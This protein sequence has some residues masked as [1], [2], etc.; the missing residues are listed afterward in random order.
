MCDRQ[1]SVYTYGVRDTRLF[2]AHCARATVADRPLSVIYT[3]RCVRV[4]VHRITKTPKRMYSIADFIPTY[5]VQTDPDVAAKLAG[6]PEFRKEAGRWNEPIPAAGELFAHQRLFVKIM[7]VYN[8]MLLISEPGTGKTLSFVAALEDLRRGQITRRAYIVERGTAVLND[9]RGQIRR[10]TGEAVTPRFYVFKTYASLSNEIRRITD[11]EQLIAEYSGCAFVLDEAHTISNTADDAAADSNKRYPDI[12]RLLRLATQTTVI[13]ATATPMINRTGELAALANLIL[14]PSRA[15]PDAAR[16]GDLDAADVETRMRGFVSFVRGEPTKTRIHQVGNARDVGSN[17]P[18]EAWPILATSVMGDIQLETY[19]KVIASSRSPS[20]A[21]E[22]INAWYRATL[23]ACAF[24]FPRDEYGGIAGGAAT[25]DFDEIDAR[26][27]VG[28]GRY[29]EATPTPGVYAFVDTIALR[30]RFSSWRH[31]NGARSLR[32]WIAGAGAP[33]GARPTHNLAR[34]SA[35]FARIIDIEREALARGEA[36]TSFV[37][38]QFKNGG[39]AILLGLVLEAFG[40]RRFDHHRPHHRSTTTTNDNDDNNNTPAAQPAYALL[41]PEIGDATRLLNAFNA[42]ENADGSHIR[43]II[44][45]QVSRD[46]I[47]LYHVTRVHILIPQ[48]NMSGV[49]QA[50]ARAIR[51]VSHDTLY[52]RSRRSI[53]ASRGVAL[54]TADAATLEAIAE[55]SRVTVRVF[56]HAAVFPNNNAAN[57]TVAAAGVVI[58]EEGTR[59]ADEELYAIATNKAY[60]IARVARALRSASVDC[61]LNRTRNIE[62]PILVGAITNGSPECDYGDCAYDCSGSGVGKTPLESIAVRRLAGAEPTREELAR[63]T[64]GLIKTL[65]SLDSARTA[66]GPNAQGVSLATV[67]PIERRA[68]VFTAARTLAESGVSVRTGH[69]RIGYMVITTCNKL[70]VAEDIT[71]IATAALGGHALVA[72]VSRDAVE[73]SNA[74]L[75]AINRAARYAINDILGAPLEAFLASPTRPLMTSW[76]MIRFIE[77]V[78]SVE[79]EIVTLERIATHLILGTPTPYRSDYMETMLREIRPEEEAQLLPG[80]QTIE[81]NLP[82]Y[83]FVT[84]VGALLAG[85][86]E[87]ET[88]YAAKNGNSRRTDAP[89]AV[90]AACGS[91]GGRLGPGPEAVRGGCMDRWTQEIELGRIASGITDPTA[92]VYFHAELA[93]EQQKLSNKFS[94]NAL[95]EDRLLRIARIFIPL[96]GDGRWR[97]LYP[98]AETRALEAVRSRVSRPGVGMSLMRLSEIIARPDVYPQPVLRIE[99][100][101]VTTAG[102]TAV[103]TAPIVALVSEWSG[104]DFRIVDRR[105]SGKSHGMVCRFFKVKKLAEI[106]EFLTPGA[107]AAD[108]LATTGGDPT[109]VAPDAPITALTRTMICKYIGQTLKAR[110]LAQASL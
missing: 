6:I 56:R 88:A 5:P 79:F 8:R 18:P 32:E 20:A 4:F 67:L 27:D 13:V 48:F 31:A 46:G 60:A 47:N 39:G 10:W 1:P 70:A 49:V 9:V 17:A 12:A 40:W 110:G 50:I 94:P 102:P 51:A 78:P 29:V 21:S 97:F 92:A 91:C 89:T 25:P 99:Q 55:A 108:I 64:E 34:V 93:I 62:L 65:R 36:G 86:E 105:E 44:G 109:S 103:E 38:S 84:N 14:P 15:F 83:V 75:F 104:D 68:A 45:S 61:I 2:A 23:Q 30:S 82:S 77:A 107:T 24:A 73:H 16:G 74:P 96:E 43:L 35:K 33:A 42:P 26:R 87:R 80:F 11:D 22:N 53:A 90:S 72:C 52:E 69:G 41:T 98:G 3:T 101:I 54:D 71:L 19:R 63:V 106:I 57:K 37:F 59:T 66:V 7:R 95:S 85:A 81:N 100:G 58:Q 28:L 76:E